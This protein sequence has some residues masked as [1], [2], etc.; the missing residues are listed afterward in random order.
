VPFMVEVVFPEW[1]LAIISHM[2]ALAVDALEGVR[3]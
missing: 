3:A 1:T 2:F